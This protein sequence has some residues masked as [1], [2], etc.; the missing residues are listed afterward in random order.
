[1]PNPQL[2]AGAPR[3]VNAQ[4]RTIRVGGNDFAY[5]DVGT[6]DAPPLVM[7]NHWGANLDNFDPRIV[8]GLAAGRRVVT[9][10]YRGVGR[11]GGDAPLTISEMA[12]DVIDVI[13]ALDLGSV[14]LLGFSLGGFVAQDVVLREPDLIRKVILT[15]TGPAGGV[16]ISK[17]G[18]VSWPLIIKGLLSFTDPKTYLFFTS[19]ANGRRAAK[20]FLARLKERTQDRDKPVTPKVF[21]RQLKAI[22]A[23]GLQAPQSLGQIQKPVL[24]A[25]GD[26]DIMVPTQNTTDMARRILAPNCTY[27]RMPAMAAFSSI[28]PNLSAPPAV[29]LMAE[30]C[31]PSP[32]FGCR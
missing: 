2:E 11:S 15:G 16:G 30:T 14:D 21:L 7:L 23:W 19:T 10:D 24:V 27:T 13:R 9:L 4:T 22:K 32:S 31:F 3:F 1:M 29:S 12:R 6:G 26:H 18:P 20:A 17:V 25:N 28:T 5:R 8:D